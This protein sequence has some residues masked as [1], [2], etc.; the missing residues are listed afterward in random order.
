MVDPT[1]ETVE[2]ERRL[3]A[4]GPVQIEAAYEDAERQ[5]FL[6]TSDI[7]ETG[8]YLFSPELPPIGLSAQVTLEL[9]KDPA[10]LRLRGTVVRH[11]ATPTGFALEFD[12]NAVSES[13]RGRVRSFVKSL[14]KAPVESE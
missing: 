8:V 1:R 6:T 13:L 5:V 3:A 12:P 10:I 2:R 9:P 4:R 14:G 7:S 11:S